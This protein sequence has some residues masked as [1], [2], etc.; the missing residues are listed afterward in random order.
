MH[1]TG[2]SQGITNF[3][4]YCVLYFRILPR[5]VMSLCNRVEKGYIIFLKSVVK[6][7]LAK[8]L[9]SKNINHI[10]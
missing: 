4:F 6:R 2:L 3:M 1:S 5:A 9:K 7:M 10:D 8:T